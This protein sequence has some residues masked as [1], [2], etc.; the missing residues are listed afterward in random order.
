LSR[1]DFPFQLHVQRDGE[2]AV[3]Y[4]DLLDKD[5]VPCPDVVLLD[6]NLPRTNGEGVLERMRQSPKCGLV[7]IIIVTSSDSPKDRAT[8]ARLGA[9]R[10]FRK[11]SDFDEFMRLGDIVKAV[12][13]R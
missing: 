11:P 9:D 10:Y 13:T 8:V 1:Q 4:I 3:H 5:E 12:L 2:A 7:P 6:L